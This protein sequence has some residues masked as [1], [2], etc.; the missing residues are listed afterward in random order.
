MRRREILTGL[1]AASVASAA[2]AAGSGKVYRIAVASQSTPVAGMVGAWSPLFSEL[3]RLGYVEGDNL[4]VL[5]FSAEGDTT[6]F[7]S[8]VREVISASPDLIIT[9]NNPFVLR[10]KALVQSIPIVA[11][12]GD[13]VAFG[14]VGNLAHPGQHNGRQL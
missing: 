7:D 11:F 12:M 8:V 6:R 13:P 3:R 1:L 2:R 4:I 10:F 5:R 9:G 14:I